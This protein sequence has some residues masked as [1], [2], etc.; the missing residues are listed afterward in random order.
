MESEFY[1]DDITRLIITKLSDEITGRVAAQIS[2]KFDSILQERFQKPAAIIAEVQDDVKKSKN[3]MLDFVAG[4][5]PVLQKLESASNASKVMLET[6][7]SRLDSFTWQIMEHIKKMPEEIQSQQHDT[8]ETQAAPEQFNKMNDTLV[9]I[10]DEIK[11]NAEFVRGAIKDMLDSYTESNSN[12][13]DSFLEEMTEHVN[14]LKKLNKEVE[15]LKHHA[16]AGNAVSV[17]EF[18]KLRD[19]LIL[20]NNEIKTNA[21]LMKNAFKETIDSKRKLTDIQKL[22]DSLE[23]KISKL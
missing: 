2:E 8:V 5:L 9:L 17:E 19:W 21:D 7:S 1:I 18:S 10:N 22:W 12:R 13:L 20:I 4:L 16:P 11:T 14:L 23:G 15:S 6:F 3:A